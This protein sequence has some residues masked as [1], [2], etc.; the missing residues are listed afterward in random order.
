MR[1]PFL[2]ETYSVDKAK[3]PLPTGLAWL[4]CLVPLTLED[5]LSEAC[6][7]TNGQTFSRV[8][9]F[10]GSACCN[11]KQAIQWDCQASP[12]QGLTQEGGGGGSR[13]GVAAPHAPC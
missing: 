11:L 4:S 8:Q 13:R 3:C 9:L 1:P 6:L 2:N 7:S 12:L 5:T 10:W